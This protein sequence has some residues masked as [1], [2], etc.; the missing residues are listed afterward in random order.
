MNPFN[1]F[2]RWHDTRYLARTKDPNKNRFDIRFLAFFR[3]VMLIALILSYVF[4][5]ITLF[6]PDWMILKM[7]FL[8]LTS[9]CIVMYTWVTEALLF[10]QYI[11]E[12][13]S[14]K[15]ESLEAE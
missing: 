3:P 11:E 6:V 7:T 9:F 13:R 8:F 2:F 15:K 5:G 10:R 1:L 4:F 14:E 12:H